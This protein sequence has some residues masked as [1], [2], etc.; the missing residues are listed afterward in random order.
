MG[1]ELQQILKDLPEWDGRS[2]GLA[3]TGTT[4]NTIEVRA[5][6]TAKDADDV[7]TLRCAV[8]ERL[9]AWLVAHHPYA[10][11]HVATAESAPPPQEP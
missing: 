9:I 5:V 1:E 4:P 2:A 7:W 6:V 8:R 11:P 10:L 3:V